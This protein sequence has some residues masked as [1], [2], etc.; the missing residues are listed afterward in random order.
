MPQDCPQSAHHF[1][2][3]SSSAPASSPPLGVAVDL[4]SKGDLPGPRALVSL[5][6]PTR[7]LSWFLPLVLVCL[8]VW[9][10]TVL[11]GRGFILG[12]T[13]GS[14]TYNRPWPVL[15]TRALF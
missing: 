9:A 14:S 15:G 6:G 4:A 13:S 2:A 1:P 5:L 3:P 12:L 7:H 10:S 8:G 11:R